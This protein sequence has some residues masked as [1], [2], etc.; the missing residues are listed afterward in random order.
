[1][2]KHNQEERRL[3]GLHIGFKKKSLDTAEAR[4]MSHTCFVYSTS[5]YVLK[6][7]VIIKL[8]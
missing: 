8:D 6:T 2:R 3:N 4:T 5:I 1:M 7:F